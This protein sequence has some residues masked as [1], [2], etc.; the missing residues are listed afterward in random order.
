MW[1][2]P[3]G[4]MPAMA[5]RARRS[6]RLSASDRLQLT[7]EIPKNGENER[8]GGKNHRRRYR[9]PS[10]RRP[11]QRDRQ[12]GAQQQRHSDE[13]GVYK[14]AQNR[15][16]RR[17]PQQ[18]GGAHVRSAALRLD[19]DGRAVG[20]CPPDLFDLCVGNGDAAVGPI[21]FSVRGPKAR[22][23]RRQSVNHDVSARLDPHLL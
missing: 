13:S 11:H 6:S 14:E 1:N 10:V 12:D 3:P 18:D 19:L 20:D 21:E 5:S 7:L 8:N 22:K 17:T 9:E 16:R 23:G 4:A 15:A 2:I